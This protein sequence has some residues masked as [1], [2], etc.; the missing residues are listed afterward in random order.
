MIVRLDKT[1]LL[2]REICDPGIP[3]AWD[4]IGDAD[5]VEFEWTAASEVFLASYRPDFLDWLKDNHFIPLA[6]PLCGLDLRGVRLKHAKLRTD[7]TGTDLRNSDLRGADLRHA[8]LKG[9]RF[10]G[11]RRYVE[12]H[13][14]AGWAV[15][16]VNSQR[17]WEGVLV[18]DLED[19]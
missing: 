3:F 7:L 8:A 19:K 18:Q 12:D 5:F 16:V 9:V 1:A 11:A 13:K 2:G 6:T 15:D 4:A 10:D 14:I 17:P